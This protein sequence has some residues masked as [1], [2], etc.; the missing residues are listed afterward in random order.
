MTVFE[1]IEKRSS[2][3]AYTEEKISKEQLDAILTAGLQAPTATNRQEIHFT[4]VDGTDPILAEVEAEKCRLRGIA[5][6]AVNAYY[7]APTLI[8]VSAEGDFKWSPLDAGI[9]VQT[10]SLAAEGLG[11]GSLII[12]SIYDALRG[13]K[14]DYFKEALKIPATHHFEIALAVGYKAAGKEPHTF[15]REK[16]VTV[17]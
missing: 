1:A 12:G 9:A 6:G 8:L 2:T 5:V 3:R 10:M 14:E 4:V 17:L 16:Q 11:L 13:E 7:S 15:D